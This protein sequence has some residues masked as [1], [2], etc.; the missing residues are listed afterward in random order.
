MQH[1]CITAHDTPKPRIVRFI[2]G[3]T[4][5]SVDPYYDP[6][7]LVM[8]QYANNS[9]KHN[10]KQTTHVISLIKQYCLTENN[11]V[12]SLEYVYFTTTTYMHSYFTL[13]LITF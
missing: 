7:S 8:I 6:L 4:N 1:A 12:L 5:F 3:F 11:Y 2:R 13:L 10:N 9:I